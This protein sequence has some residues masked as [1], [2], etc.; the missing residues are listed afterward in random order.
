ME[1]RSSSRSRLL[2]PWRSWWP[3]TVSETILTSRCLSYFHVLVFVLFLEYSWHFG[4][5]TTSFPYFWTIWASCL[6][7]PWSE[8]F[9]GFGHCYLLICCS[10]SNPIA[11]FVDINLLQNTRFHFD[12]ERVKGSDT[13]A[14]LGMVEGDTIEA[15][16]VN[17]FFILTISVLQFSWWVSLIWKLWQFRTFTFVF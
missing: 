6:S 7:G 12:G 17:F 4:V 11:I 8:H 16:L 2:L 14:S 5:W 10:L 3:P 15:F 1:T 13:A 9:C